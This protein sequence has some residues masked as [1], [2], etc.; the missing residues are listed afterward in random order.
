M[1]N[2]R[3]LDLIADAQDRIQGSHRILENHSNS[4]S[5][6]LSHLCITQLEEVATFKVNPPLDFAIT[7]WDQAQQR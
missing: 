5:P 1:F 7:T 6:Q 2:D 4:I 3:F